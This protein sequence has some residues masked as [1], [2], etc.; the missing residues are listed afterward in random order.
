MNTKG[1]SVFDS[2]LRD[3]A[4]GKG[5]SFSIEDRLAIV[6]LLDCLGIDLIEAG[7]PGS[8]PKELAFFERA[9]SLQ[10]QHAKLV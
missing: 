3:G 1:I 2:T 6:R 9:S 5:I 4:Q 7:N 10:L 8:N